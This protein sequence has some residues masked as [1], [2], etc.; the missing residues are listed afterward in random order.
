MRRRTSC[1]SI[2]TWR[3]NFAYANWPESFNFWHRK[4]WPYLK[5]ELAHDFG[6]FG[7]TLFKALKVIG[8]Q[9]EIPLFPLRKEFVSLLPKQSFTQRRGRLVLAFSI[10]QVINASCILQGLVISLQII[11]I[12]HLMG[13]K[14]NKYFRAYAL[15]KCSNAC[16]D[17]YSGN[18][19]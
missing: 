5:D 17:P 1:Q 6:D 18:I 10:G 3:Y 13:S 16:Q 9:D 11:G 7:G 8:C 4:F 14:C 2:S 19:I 15:T 12:N